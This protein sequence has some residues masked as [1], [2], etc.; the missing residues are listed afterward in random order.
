MEIILPLTAVIL[1]AIFVG[2]L[3]RERLKFSCP[4]CDSSQVR[5][6]EKQLKEL[7]QD[8]TIGYGMKLDVKLTMETKYHCQACGHTWTVIAPET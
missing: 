7:K 8:H 3:R 1:V 4:E 2:Y 6:V 5:V